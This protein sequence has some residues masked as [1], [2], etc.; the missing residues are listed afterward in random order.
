MSAQ[1]QT[2]VKTAS[3][4]KPSFTPILSGLLQRTCACGQHTVAGGECEECRQKRE[5]MVQRAA[6]SAAPANSVPS[7]VH[8]VLS[9]SG[10]PL[11]VGT[12]SF[13]EPRFG[14][15]FSQV[16]VH[17]D[18][19]AA[20][21]ARAVNALA[22]AVGRDVVFGM[23]QYEP[24]TSEGKRL[25]AHELM[26]TIQ[27]DGGIQRSQALLTLTDAQD[28]VEQEAHAAEEAVMYGQLPALPLSKTTQ[29]A[30]Q[31]DALDAGMPDSPRDAG[32]PGGVL[33][34]PL[35]PIPTPTPSLCPSVPTSTPATCA[36][37]HNAYCEAA[38]CFPGSPWLT[39]VCAASGEVCE[40][41]EAFTFAS[42]EGL[43]LEGC[44]IAPPT[45][46]TG[47]VVDKGRWFLRTNAGIWGHWRAAFEAIHDPTRPIPSTLTPEWASAVSTC[48]RD[49][50][51]SG[52]CCQ[53]HVRAEQ[54]A[55]DRVGPYPSRLFGPLPSDVPGAPTCSAI[56]HAFARGMPFTGDFGNVADRIAYGFRRCCP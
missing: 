38:R 17:T 28:S 41:A 11:D 15:E 53:A 27:Q 56:V 39:C 55:I 36:A 25:L 6:V 23:G 40:A 50:I 48:R 2:Q 26:H 54:T 46:P 13:M 9:S 24:G 20:E 45:R 30:R 19:K 5:G 49:G 14:Y 4:S 44:V 8:E 37:R 21:S 29:V 43:L 52:T 51:G 47:P 34:S 12:R 31:A 1:K 3:I 10:Q 33:A 22:Y 42:T 32:L 7:I 35:A 18:A 16:R